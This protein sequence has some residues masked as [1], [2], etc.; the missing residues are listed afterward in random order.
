VS[1]LGKLCREASHYLG[2]QLGGLA[3]GFV[4][5]PLF[6]RVL[7]VGEYGMLCLTFQVA[8]MAA[9]LSKM[10]LQHSIQRFYQ[11][12]AASPQ[13]LRRFYSTLLFGAALCAIAVAILFVIGLEIV[14][15]SLVSPLLKKTLLSG[16]ALI[17]I[18]GLQPIAMNF[19]RAQR[20]TKAFNALDVLTQ[21][22]SLALV[23][24]LL[25]AW[26]RSVNVVLIGT[27]AVE[28]ASVVVT[29]FLLLPPGVI[30]FRAF[31]QGLFW[32]AIAFG[33][34][35]VGYELSAVILDSGDRIL[36]QHYLGSQA[37]GYYS[38]GYNMSNY[39]SSFLRSPVNLA[40]FPIYM[41]LWVTRGPDETRE[42]LSTTLDNFIMVAMCVMTGVA[43]TARYAVIILGSRKLQQ[44]YPLLP[45]LVLGLMLNT[46][47]MFFNAGLVIHKKTLK[48][49]KFVATSA[50][51]NIA[52]NVVLIPQIGLQGAAIATLLSYA[53]FLGLSARAS[54]A[55][56][57]LRLNFR[58]YLRYMVAAVIGTVLVS[59]IQCSSDFL[60]LVIRGALSVLAYGGVLW[61]IDQRFRLIVRDTARFA[62]KV[63]RKQESQVTAAPALETGSKL[64][65]VE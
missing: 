6:T 51:L 25:F 53:F 44:A 10:G 2:G 18:R 55:L 42:F 30:S 58:A 38:A 3:L 11:E 17:F 21:G 16:S 36:V 65:S 56:L 31:D 45:V 60:N 22:A 24:L 33:F 52:L 35:L 14:P 23:C 27:V 59:R 13:G 26:N 29:V 8:A 50:A 48:M 64:T 43:V 57:P 19:L 54:F 9:V 12:H 15:D 37:L 40:M 47:Q 49:L 62:S 1:D 34:P 46:L 5:F 4:S 39:I 61:A 28:L 20:R 63:L 32:G 41:N 7:S